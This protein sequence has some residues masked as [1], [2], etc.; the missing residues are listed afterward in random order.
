MFPEKAADESSAADFAAILEPPQSDQQFAPSGQQGLAREHVAKD[1]AVAAQEHP[2]SRFQCPR[3]IHC[4]A[5]IQERPAPRA[6]PG[7]RAPP[8][9]PSG[10]TL[11]IDEGPKIVKAIRSQHAR[12]DK[13]PERSLHFRLQPA[14]AAHDIGEK[15]CPMVS[16]KL[17]DRLRIRAQPASLFLACLAV[18]DHPVG[19]LAHEKCDRRDA[20]RHDTAFAVRRRIERRR[21]RGQPSPANR[22]CEAKLVERPR[23]VSADASR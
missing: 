14:G 8:P 13:L 15:R 21:M 9:P 1:D 22:A 16:Q 11:G 12:R 4:F 19:I 3:A 2:A 18:R 5:G 23:I 17:H 10:A 6:V 7:T 20:S